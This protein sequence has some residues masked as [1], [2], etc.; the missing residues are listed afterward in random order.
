MT[1]LFAARNF[2]IKQ[3]YDSKLVMGFEWKTSIIW[4]QMCEDKSI[5][6]PTK[7]ANKKHILSYDNAD[8]EFVG[9]IL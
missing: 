5:L 4:A 3:G 1:M 2:I 8:K 9:K 7:N 6:S